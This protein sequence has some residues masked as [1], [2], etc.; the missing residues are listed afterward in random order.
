MTPIAKRLP[1]RQLKP[2][3]IITG[4]MFDDFRIQSIDYHSDDV[5]LRLQRARE[6]ASLNIAKTCLMLNVSDNLDMLFSVLTEQGSKCDHK[7]RESTP[8]S[9]E[10]RLCGV[11]IST[12]LPE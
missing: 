10:C 5:T 6:P 12:G 1:V 2:G 8:Q 7:W 11:R 4:L 3:Q 9:V